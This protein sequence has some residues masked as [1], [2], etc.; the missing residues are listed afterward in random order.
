M[1][2]G[3]RCARPGPGRVPEGHGDRRDDADVLV[4]DR[5]VEPLD[6][7]ACLERSIAC[8]GVGQPAVRL[9]EAGK[10]SALQAG[11]LSETI[12]SGSISPESSPFPAPAVPNSEESVCH[13]RLRSVG[14]STNTA[15]RGFA[16]VRRS[17]WR[18]TGSRS[19]CLASARFTGGPRSLPGARS[20]KWCAGPRQ[21]RRSASRTSPRPPG[22]SRGRRT[23]VEIPFLTQ[24][25]LLDVGLPVGLGPIV[26]PVLRLVL[27]S[28]T[29]EA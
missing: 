15:R 5:L 7:A 6:D 18:R 3:L 2:G 1:A 11:P 29:G 23:R 25:P 20:T 26:D 10:R 9:D 12:T 13:S 22:S 14:G 4:G 21:A 28:A 27:F 24:H 17:F 8:A 19:P 16:I